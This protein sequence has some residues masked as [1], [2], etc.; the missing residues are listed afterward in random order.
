MAL[1]ARGNEI[2]F[3][4]AVLDNEYLLAEIIAYAMNKRPK[5]LPKLCA[6]LKPLVAQNACVHSD[7]RDLSMVSQGWDE[8][9]NEIVNGKSFRDYGMLPAFRLRH[10]K[11]V[12]RTVDLSALRKPFLFQ[13]TKKFGCSSS[14][15]TTFRTLLRVLD[16]C[17][18]DDVFHRALQD[19]RKFLV[20]K[21]I[22][23]I[24]RAR[25][26]RV[27]SRWTKKC[28]PPVLVD[29][30]WRIHIRHVEDYASTCGALCG[31]IISRSWCVNKDGRSLTVAGPWSAEGK[32]SRIF[33]RENRCKGA[34]SHFTIIA[35]IFG[36]KDEDSF[37]DVLDMNDV[38]AYDSDYEEE[39]EEEEEEDI[40]AQ[41][42]FA[43]L[44]SAQL[45][46][47]LI[48]DPWG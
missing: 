16:R 26:P 28:Q 11:F 37:A 15:G 41:F 27:P 4:E 14:P 13:M 3:Q 39:E 43:A 5:L 48:P 34:G 31:E 30:L 44:S 33:S 45:N 29:F 38:V 19:Y 18:E 23:T 6:K 9:V 2:A 7:V 8:K 40:E 10:V 17:T 12:A 24:A 32:I 36:Q 42:W 35:K 20:V 25:S 1:R 47:A 22:E 21:S 46:S